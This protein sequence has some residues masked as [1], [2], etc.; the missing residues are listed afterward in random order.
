[1]DIPLQD[2]DFSVLDDPEFKWKAAI[3][4]RRITLD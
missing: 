1:M 4:C 2:F 3:E